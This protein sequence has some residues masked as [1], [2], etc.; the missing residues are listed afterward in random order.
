MLDPSCSF[1]VA[2]GCELAEVEDALKVGCGRGCS[3]KGAEMLDSRRVPI[4]GMDVLVLV[5]MPR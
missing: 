1:R 5:L 2:R 4:L 3:K